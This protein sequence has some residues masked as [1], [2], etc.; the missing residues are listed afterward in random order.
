MIEKHETP[1]EMLERKEKNNFV[2]LSS[3]YLL[4]KILGFS[5]RF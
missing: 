1:E 2:V 3:S 4:I 5:Y